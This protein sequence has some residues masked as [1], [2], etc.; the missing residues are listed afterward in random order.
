MKEWMSK[1]IRGGIIGMIIIFI[2]SLLILIINLIFSVPWGGLFIEVLEIGIPK[3]FLVMPWS[4]PWGI[5]FLLVRWFILGAIIALIRY[6]LKNN[7]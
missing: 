3:S 6:K 1:A 2:F 4:N 7:S 5:L